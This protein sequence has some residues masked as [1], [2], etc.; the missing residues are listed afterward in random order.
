[1]MTLWS[2]SHFCAGE[3]KILIVQYAVITEQTCSPRA[4]SHFPRAESAMQFSLLLSSSAS[5]S[6][7]SFPPSPSPPSFFLAQLSRESPRWYEFARPARRS[8][9]GR[10]FREAVLP[11]EAGEKD[12]FP[13]W[14][15]NNIC[16]LRTAELARRLGEYRRR[17][18]RIESNVQAERRSEKASERREKERHV[19]T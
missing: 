10:V 5:A 1:M 2:L 18:R 16:R 4:F 7:L 19:P 13:G 6:S 9:I 14:S 12:L 8:A 11:A 15:W 3:I 17:R